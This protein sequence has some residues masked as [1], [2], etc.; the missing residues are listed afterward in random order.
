MVDWWVANIIN[1]PNL[2]FP[3]LFAWAVVAIG[4]IVLHELAH[5]WA[6]IRLGDDT[7]IVMGHMTWNPLVHM[8]GFSLVVFA[9]LGIAWGAMPVNPSRLRGRHGSAI[10]SAAGPAMNFALAAV[11][12]VL[13][14]L[15]AVFAPKLG[16]SDPLLGNFQRFFF[17]GVMLNVVLGLFNLA[18][19]MPLDG[20]RILAEYW[21]AYA[22]LADSENGRWVMLGGFI[23]FFWFGADIVFDIGA[24]VS[25]EMIDASVGALRAVVP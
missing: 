18:P 25:L 11:A 3:A 10:V 24:T 2:G 8:G 13:C 16:V 6:A 4:S 21:P 15:W 22:R 12:C 17:Y 9:I 1:D 14:A 7:P 19:I 20:G 5:G 23:L